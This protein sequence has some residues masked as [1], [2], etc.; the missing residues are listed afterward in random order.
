MLADYIEE[1]K[2]MK[3]QKKL[4]FAISFIFLFSCSGPIAHSIVDS[5]EDG[6]PKILSIFNGKSII[7][8]VEFSIDGNI[9]SRSFYRNGCLFGKWTSGEFFNKEDLVLKYYG[10]GI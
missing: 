1:Y 5:F 8:K 3:H 4:I 6:S 9:L 7:Q 2:V 10:N